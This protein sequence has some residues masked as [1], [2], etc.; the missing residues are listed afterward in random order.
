MV[1]GA[2]V[3]G[4]IAGLTGG[5]GAGAGQYCR[6]QG[7]SVKPQHAGFFDRFLFSWLPGQGGGTGFLDVFRNVAVQRGVRP[8]PEP[9][10]DRGR[11][12]GQSL[13]VGCRPTREE[14]TAVFQVAAE[15]RR[16]VLAGRPA[17]N[18]RQFC[19]TLRRQANCRADQRNVARANRSC[20]G[21]YLSGE[22]RVSGSRF[23]AGRR[24]GFARRAPASAGR[25]RIGL[26][27]VFSGCGVWR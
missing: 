10:P 16:A 13:G 26:R 2:V 20:G 19:A 22:K 18:L 27:N 24:R 15:R 3:R 4:G 5:V 23:V 9:K 7:F 21:D 8:L 14:V 11:G 12:A 17:G 6:R 1:R 25:V